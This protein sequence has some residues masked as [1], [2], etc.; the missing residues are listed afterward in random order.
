MFEGIGVGCPVE[1]GRTPFADNGEVTLVEV[2]FVIVVVVD[3]DA[4]V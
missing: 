1:E 2:F 4:E 3:A